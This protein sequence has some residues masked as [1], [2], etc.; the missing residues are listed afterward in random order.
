MAP[1]CSLAEPTLIDF[2]KPKELG[3]AEVDVLILELARNGETFAATD[4]LRKRR[5]YSLRDAKQFVDELVA[6]V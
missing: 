5:G 2:S 3:E 6:K 4:L 1:Y